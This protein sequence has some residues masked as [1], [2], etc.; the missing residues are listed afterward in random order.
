MPAAVWVETRVQQSVGAGVQLS[1]HVHVGGPCRGL[2][3]GGLSRQD[4]LRMHA[5]VG[6]SV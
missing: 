4:W 6:V 1:M 2:R 5:W 3:D